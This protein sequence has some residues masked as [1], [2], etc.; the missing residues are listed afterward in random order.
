[1]AGY[2]DTPAG[3]GSWSSAG[4]NPF[5]G[6]GGGSPMLGMSILGGLSGLGSFFSG[7]SQAKAQKEI[8]KMRI[9][10]QQRQ[11]QQ[12]VALKESTLDPFRQQMQQARNLSMLDM[13]G[14]Y[15]PTASYS[16]GPWATDI[17]RQ[18][19]PGTAKAALEANPPGPRQPNYTPSADLLN[20]L[21]M[22]KQ[23]V[24]GGQNQAPSM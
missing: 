17:Y 14:N 9:A 21:S 6:G 20:W 2:M 4:G 15:Q 22:I 10:E 12:D 19:A 11:Q 18:Q 24:A 5:A 3:L 13:R 1:M 16:L 7:M 23:N 8:E